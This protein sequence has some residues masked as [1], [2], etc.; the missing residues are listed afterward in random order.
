[1]LKVNHSGKVLSAKRLFFDNRDIGGDY[2]LG[3]WDDWESE[4]GFE[5]G[6]VKAGEDPVAAVGFE[7]RVDKLIAVVHE[8][9][10][11]RLVH[12]VEIRICKR[13]F[14]PTRLQELTRQQKMTAINLRGYPFSIEIDLLVVTLKVKRQCVEIQ[15]IERER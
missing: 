15:T 8:G 2:P 3:R 1:M 4:D 10:A 6:L 7:V 5:V 14:I 11:A 12:I 9:N 13:Y